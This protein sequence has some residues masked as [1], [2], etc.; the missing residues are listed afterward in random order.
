MIRRLAS[1]FLVTTI[2]FAPTACKSADDGSTIHMNP[3][4]FQPT[5]PP[6]ASA[7][8]A[9]PANGT[10]DEPIHYN[11][12]PPQ[13]ATARRKR[14]HPRGSYTPAGQ[15]DYA[16]LKRLN[17]TDSQGRTVYAALDDSCYVEVPG[18]PKVARPPMPTGSRDVE[19]VPVDCAAVMDD[20]AWDDCSAATLSRTAKGDCVCAATIGNPPPPPS[21]NACPK[22]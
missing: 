11:P 5:P 14:A 17:P 12:P 7:S 6:T 15:V 4:P 13:H 2:A 21:A 19:I 8:A 20:P 3:P 22:K 10:A 9:P 16:S 18:D 1:S